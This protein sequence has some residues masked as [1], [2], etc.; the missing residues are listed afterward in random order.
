MGEIKKGISLLKEGLIAKELLLINF[1]IHH[2][3]FFN[4]LILMGA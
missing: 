1:S 3:L 2:L 4:I